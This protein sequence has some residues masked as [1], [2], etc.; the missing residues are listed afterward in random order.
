[1]TVSVASTVGGSFTALTGITNFMIAPASNTVDF[2][3]TFDLT[4]L[5][6]TDNV[7]LLRIDIA[8]NHLG[9]NQFAGLSEIRFD[10]VLVPEPGTMVLGGLGGFVV[11]LRRRRR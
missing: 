10:G 8:T 6:A 3:E 2:G 5:A 4:A 1:V 11:T 9:D 7:R